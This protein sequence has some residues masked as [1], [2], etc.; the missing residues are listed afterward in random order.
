ML[1]QIKQIIEQVS[2]KEAGAQGMSSELTSSVVQATGGSIVSGLKE[3]IT[4]GNFSQLTDLFQGSGNIASNGAVTSIVSNLVGT[5][6]SKLGID[7]GVAN[8]FAGSVV[9]QII[10]M[11]VTKAKDS[12]L[13]MTDLMGS[14]AGGSGSSGLLDSLGGL[15][16]DQNK[17]G[18]VGLDDAVSALKGFFK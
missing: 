3:S 8:N 15:G 14:L 18:K 2:S 4:N 13:S 7:S 11:V 5:L 16:L 1:E 10:G 6:S 12:N 17:D 9:P